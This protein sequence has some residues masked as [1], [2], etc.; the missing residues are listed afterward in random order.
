[1][2]VTPVPED[3]RGLAA[4]V[5]EASLGGF[6][7]VLELDDD[8]PPAGRRVVERA[9]HLAW[10]LVSRVDIPIDRL[11][12]RP[13]VQRRGGEEPPS[14]EEW[15]SALGSGVAREHPLTAEQLQLV[16][17]AYPAVN[18]DLDAAVRRLAG[19]R[20]DRLATRISPQRGWDDL[21]LAP[22]RIGQ[23]REL[24][25]RYRNRGVVYGEWGFRAAPSSGIVALFAGPSG[26]G[27][28]MAAEILAGDLALD[29]FKLDLSAVVSKYIGETEKN[30]EAVFDA[31]A[32]GNVVL[33]FDEA[34][35]L[36]GKRTEV[37]DAHDRYANIEVSY[38]L[39][40][41]ERYEG[42]VVLATNLQKN[43]DQA[44]LRRLHA[45]VEFPSPD[46]SERRRIWEANLPPGVPVSDLDL[47]FLAHQFSLTGGSIRNAALTA[48]FLAAE[49]GS[50]L[51]M[52]CVVLALR[53]EFQK[54]GRLITQADF[55]PY[56][57]FVAA[58]GGDITA[59]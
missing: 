52:E 46:E 28:T 37:G 10:A 11:P 59:R 41:L 44:F 50:G 30:L 39:Q 49:A 21:V 23:L 25:A 22:D 47:D 29:L 6:G 53:R 18:G 14:D 48:A 51:T 13:W 58:A 15:L 24:A 55:G 3:D 12:R 36:F 19:G 1:F 33:F 8:L 57:D 34:D 35:A 32:A 26:T 45:V 17:T 7:V 5:R 38:L 16:A 27:K 4:I 40:R 43:I 54:L 9:D 2:L 20:L 42:I 31:A 56:Y